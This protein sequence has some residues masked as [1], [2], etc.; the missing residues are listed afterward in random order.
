MKKEVIIDA[1]KLAYATICSDA[2]QMDKDEHHIFA[3]FN[4]AVAKT[5]ME[6]LCFYISDGEDKER[7][8]HLR[9][10]LEDARFCLSLAAHGGP[11][12][13]IPQG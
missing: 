8:E 12:G 13:D 5:L 11:G 4:N 1:M 9:K 7:E 10:Q 6:A 2:I 3:D